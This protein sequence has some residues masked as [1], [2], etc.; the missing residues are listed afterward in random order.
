MAGQQQ[1]QQQQSQQLFQ[2]MQQMQQYQQMQQRQ[3][4]RQQQQQQQQQQQGRGM[5]GFD[6]FAQGQSQQLQQQ[7]GG[8]NL[9]IPTT[10]TTATNPKD[11]PLTPEILNAFLQGLNSA[12]FSRQAI[13]DFSAGQM[14]MVQGGQRQ[15]SVQP[16]QPGRGFT[17]SPVSTQ[18]SS[19]G[20]VPS[21]QNGSDNNLMAM[22]MMMNNQIG[23]GNLI[24]NN[25]NG[26]AGQ[27]DVNLNPQNAYPQPGIHTPEAS[28]CSK[29]S[30]VGSNE[31]SP[32]A[33]TA[34]GGQGGMSSGQSPGESVNGGGGQMRA[35]TTRQLSG[36]SSLG[37]EG[38]TSSSRRGSMVGQ[39]RAGSMRAGLDKGE[40]KR[41]AEE[42]E[43]LGHQSLRRHMGE[44]GES[45]E[46]SRSKFPR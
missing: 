30:V 10:T 5:Y 7:H 9:S 19:G 4:Q 3:S 37:G 8:N 1:S 45:C 31:S 35:G 34:P 23:G 36:S 12:G 11:I 39:D 41:K 22:M 17:A 2:Q 40:H 38:A 33:T 32:E 42:E 26:L 6:S 29:D 28:A 44:E 14:G 15:Q 46:F 13:S 20:F 43:L 27:Q 21:P 25:G 16:Q 24:N 18:S